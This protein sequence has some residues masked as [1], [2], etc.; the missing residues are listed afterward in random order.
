MLETG[1]TETF[2]HSVNAEAMAGTVVV[3]GFLTGARP[4]I[5]VLPVMEKE[6]RVQV[7]NT[8]PVAALAAAAIAAHQLVPV[9]DQTFAMDEAAEAYAH[10]AVGGQHFGK[11]AI[12]VD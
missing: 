11:I 3:I 8:G 7:N 6:L 9:I 1:G 5:D 2:A 12:S 10:L 4:T